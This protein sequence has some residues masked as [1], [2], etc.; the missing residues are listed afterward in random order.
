MMWRLSLSF[1]T[2]NVFVDLTH[3]ELS[4]GNNI[5]TYFMS[6]TN[7]LFHE[8]YRDGILYKSGFLMWRHMC[9]TCTDIRVRRTMMTREPGVCVSFLIYRVRKGVT[10]TIE[11]GFPPKSK[12]Y[13]SVGE[14]WGK[15]AKR[16]GWKTGPF[17]GQKEIYGYLVLFG[18]NWLFDETLNEFSFLYFES[19]KF[20]FHSKFWTR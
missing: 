15:C 1:V 12:V 6:Y 16:K 18:L 8:L 4:A 20:H 5:S 19:T 13:V 7:E 17:T 9:D 10:P 11:D 14:R 3:R 2:R